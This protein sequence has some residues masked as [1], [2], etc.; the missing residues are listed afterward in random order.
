MN[1]NIL[2]LLTLSISFTNSVIAA[3]F[4]NDIYGTSA[5]VEN[6]LFWI[7]KHKNVFDDNETCFIGTKDKYNFI[8]FKDSLTK[9]KYVH[10]LDYKSIEPDTI[11][12]RIDKEKAHKKDIK[13][14]TFELDSFFNFENKN[15]IMYQIDYK[16]GWW[17]THGRV[18]LNLKKYND[19]YEKFEYFCKNAHNTIDIK[20]E[21]IL[22]KDISLLFSSH[23][24]KQKK[25][26]KITNKMPS[27]K[28]KPEK[29]ELTKYEWLRTPEGN[30]SLVAYNSSLINTIKGKWIKPS[31]AKSGWECKLE[32]KQDQNGQIK[33][34]RK[35]NCKPYT[36]KFYQ[37]IYQAV[38]ESSPLPIPKDKRLF[39]DR[40]TITFSVE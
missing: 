26:K 38:M 8:I 1:K 18:K 20:N 24:E 31:N 5:L 27:K 19:I 36:N 30:S 9:K 21:Q 32:I 15:K 14:K 3:D 12:Y 16:S 17:S 28:T 29:E 10:F 6:E 35:L 7:G 25:E 34:V 40:I 4:N 13:N 2:G 11:T 33:G 37:S 39:D 23:Y 22:P